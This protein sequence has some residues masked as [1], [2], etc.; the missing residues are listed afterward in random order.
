MRGPV[1]RNDPRAA[2]HDPEM[3]L[4]ESDGETTVIRP[5]LDEVVTLNNA[6]NEI[7]RGP[8]AIEDWEFETRVGVGRDE[9]VALQGSLHQLLS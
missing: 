9:A 8:E 4:I 7:L 6:L 3:E 5:R 2:G 1:F